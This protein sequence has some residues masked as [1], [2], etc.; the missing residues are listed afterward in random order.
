MT[1]RLP[2]ALAP[3]GRVSAT[4]NVAAAPSSTDSRSR[5]TVAVS[6]S[7]SLMVA[8]ARSVPSTTL[9]SRG[10]TR[11][12]VIENRS[13]SSARV[14]SI[15]VT[16]TVVAPAPVMVSV[17]LAASKSAPEAVPVAVA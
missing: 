6:A 9:P 16:G 1:G 7:L 14:S 4:R 10:D 13:L 11:V 3:P 2:A 17:P 8:V 5:V 12:S 15:T